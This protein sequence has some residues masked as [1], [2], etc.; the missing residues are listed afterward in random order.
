MSILTG[1]Y[2]KPSLA[3]PKFFYGEFGTNDVGKK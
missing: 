2:L 3:S 1:S